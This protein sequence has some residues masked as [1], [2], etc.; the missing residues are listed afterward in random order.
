[1]GTLY[2]QAYSVEPTLDRFVWIE[3]LTPTGRH[4]LGAKHTWLETPPRGAKVTLKTQPDGFWRWHYQGLEPGHYAVYFRL[5]DNVQA[6]PVDWFLVY[7]AK[8]S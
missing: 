7:V 3:R 4:W 5:V 8:D 6:K 2:V 1:M